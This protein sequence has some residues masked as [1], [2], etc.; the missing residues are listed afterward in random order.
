MTRMTDGFAKYIEKATS[1]I[2]AVDAAVERLEGKDF[3]QLKMSDEWYLNPGGCY[4]VKPYPTSLFAFTIGSG[5]YVESGFKIVSAHTDCP[6][7]KVKPSPEMTVEGYIKLNTEVYGGPIN[8]SWMDRM[9]SLSGRVVLRSDDPFKPTSVNVDF[10]CSLMTIPSVAIHMN[11]EVNKGIELNRQKDML[12]MIGQ[13]VEGFE[14]ENWLIGVL[15]DELSIKKE[16][17]LDFDLYV[18][19]NEKAEYFGIENCFLSSPRIDNLT[20]VY[21]AIESLLESEHKDYVN[22]VACFDNE[23]VGSSTK[24]GADSTL[25]AIITERIALALNKTRSQYLRLLAG[26]FLIST[27]GAHALHPNAADKNDPTSKPVLNKGIVIKSTASQNYASE[28]DSI[29]VV[30]QLCEKAGI[31]Y[32]RFVNRSDT[33]GGKTLGPLMTKYLPVRAVDIGIPMLAM[34]AAK[35]TMGTKDLEDMTTLLKTFFNN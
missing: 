2:Q 21:S 34:H 26:S 16:E 3:Q 32:Q 20:M 29:G 27:D 7:F 23:E 18:Y 33:P 30:I 24:Q 12:P 10:G 14:K 13:F 6:G 15:A 1:P 19:I 25:L 22:L 28:S 35:E 31:P 17:I 5:K 9:L 4:Y 8:S 11:R